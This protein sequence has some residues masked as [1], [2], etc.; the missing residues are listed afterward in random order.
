MELRPLVCRRRSPTNCSEDFLFPLPFSAT[1]GLIFSYLVLITAV[2]CA[3]TPPPWL[4]TLAIQ[5]IYEILPPPFKTKKRGL[6]LK[7][8]NS[9][10]AR[11]GGGRSGRERSRS[12]R[13]LVFLPPSQTY[14]GSKLPACMMIHMAIEQPLFPWRLGKITDSLPAFTNC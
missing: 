9:H 1:L 13:S 4:P 3:F 6:L 11:R 12:T 14:I 7:D 5:Y 8:A 10:Q 2:V